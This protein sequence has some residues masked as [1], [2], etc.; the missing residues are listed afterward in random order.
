MPH[1]KL[2]RRTFPCPCHA[3]V[4]DMTGN[5]QGPPAPRALD[6]FPVRIEAGVIKVENREVELVDADALRAPLAAA[7]M[8]TAESS[9]LPSLASVPK[10]A[11]M[12]IAIAMTPIPATRFW[13][14][15]PRNCRLNQ[16]ASAITAVKPSFAFPFNL[17]FDITLLFYL[18]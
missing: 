4:F 17:L 14:A 2:V 15:F 6:L 7:A 1:P 16:P 12:P 10:C 3:S 13:M 5:V 18:V 11:L 8:K 9:V